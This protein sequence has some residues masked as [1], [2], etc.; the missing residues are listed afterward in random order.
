MIMFIDILLQNFRVLYTFEGR[1]CLLNLF[2]SGMDPIFEVLIEGEVEDL[3]MRLV[4][5]YH[6]ITV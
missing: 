5:R 3:I 4:H 1:I 6:D 2:E